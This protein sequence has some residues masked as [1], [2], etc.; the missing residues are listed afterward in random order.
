MYMLVQKTPR[1]IYGLG[2][3]KAFVDLMVNYG[4]FGIQNLAY[5]EIM[6]LK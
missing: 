4:K 5:Q 6:L 2:L 3:T 1:V